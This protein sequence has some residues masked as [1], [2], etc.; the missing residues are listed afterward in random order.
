MLPQVGIVV[1]PG[2]VGLGVVPAGIERG[3]KV[4][5]SS[6]YRIC[7][8]SAAGIADIGFKTPGNIFEYVSII[9]SGLGFWM[10]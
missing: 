4:N 3:L 5:R 9:G 1:E 10:I 6:G 2:R 8:C 7:S